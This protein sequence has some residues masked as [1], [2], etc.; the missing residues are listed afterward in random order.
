MTTY[1][2]RQLAI[3]PYP[4][5]HTQLDVFRLPSVLI[6]PLNYTFIKVLKNILEFF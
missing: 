6:F 2:P 1:T 4:D 3:Q 5:T